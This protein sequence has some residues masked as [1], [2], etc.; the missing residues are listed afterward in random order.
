M[1]EERFIKLNH[2][3][4]DMPLR[5]ALYWCT[6]ECACMGCAN[7][8]GGLSKAGFSKEDWKEW[9]RSQA[10]YIVHGRSEWKREELKPLP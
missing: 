2:L 10:D 1:D 5:H 4:N 7:V 6:S 8:S 9:W 3:M